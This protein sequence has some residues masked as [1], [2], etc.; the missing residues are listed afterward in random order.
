LTKNVF[1]HCRNH[2]H[3]AR[4]SAI[5]LDIIASAADQQRTLRSSSSSLLLN[6][7]HHH[8]HHHHYSTST[9]RDQPQQRQRQQVNNNNIMTPSPPP[10]SEEKPIHT[11]TPTTGSGG[12]QSTPSFV[13]QAKQTLANA[14]ETA[15][16]TTKRIVHSAQSGLGAVQGQISEARKQM[17]LPQDNDGDNT[18]KAAQHEQQGMATQE[19]QM[20]EAGSAASYEAL[21][22]TPLSSPSEF[23]T[24]GTQTGGPDV[25]SGGTGGTTT[26]TTSGGGGGGITGALSGM[27]H[28]VTET[29]SSAA[30]RVGSMVGMGGR[31]STEMPSS[32]TF[33]HPEG[34][35]TTGLGEQTPHGGGGGTSSSSS[36]WEDYKKKA[37]DTVTA[38]KETTGQ[39]AETG[40][41]RTS[42]MGQATKEKM[43][44]AYDQTSQKAQETKEGAGNMMQGMK[45]RTAETTDS[46]KQ[47]A[48]GAWQ[49]V[50]GMFGSTEEDVTKENVHTAQ[51]T[52]TGDTKLAQQAKRE[53]DV[54]HLGDQAKERI[55]EMQRK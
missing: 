53:Q 35:S 32:S 38:G 10:S 51:P 39:M 4:A 25:A 47:Q 14:S 48:T 55:D 41:R 19:R 40:Q 8:H 20:P 1:I 2:P 13:E 54:R 31:G 34:G 45:E 28:K 50:K 44:Q 46:I 6:Y 11:A 52:L 21:Y 15:Q 36:T 7:H 22:S 12:A 16:A 27:A 49:G 18:F 42:E 43:G 17:G 23:T 33:Y 30:E 29:M 5:L 37:S 9:D 3:C 24:L 26:T